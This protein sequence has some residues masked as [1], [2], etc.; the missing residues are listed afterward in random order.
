MKRRQAGSFVVNGALASGVL[1]WA[2]RLSQAGRTAIDWVVIGL[3]VCAILFNLVQL[4]RRLHGSGGGRDVWHLQCTVLFWIV[5]L[6]NTALLR[7][8]DA[9]SWR[10]WAGWALIAVAAADTVTLFRKERRAV[11]ASS[12]P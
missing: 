9:G 3:L 5:G 8:E 10:L 6:M 2:I 7:P 12:G 1:A 4:G 11:A